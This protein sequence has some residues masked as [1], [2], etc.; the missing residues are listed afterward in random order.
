M[1]LFTT[2]LILLFSSEAFALLPPLYQNINEIT[3]ILNNKEV[4]DQLESGRSILKIIKTKS[5]Y[6]I[7]ANECTLEVKVVYHGTKNSMPGPAEFQIQPEK[8]QCHK[9]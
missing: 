7:V 1:R 9:K 2:M 6:K 8:I 4:T 5:G 3:A